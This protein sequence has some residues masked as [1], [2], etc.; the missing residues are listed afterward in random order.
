MS[1]VK[2]RTDVVSILRST[3]IRDCGGETVTSGGALFGGGVGLSKGRVDEGDRCVSGETSL[4][5]SLE[6]LSEPS[7][8]RARAILWTLMMTGDR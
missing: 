3:M 8:L 4:I 1:T 7:S 5:S 2:K 6:R